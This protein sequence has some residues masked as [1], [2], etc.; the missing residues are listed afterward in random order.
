LYGIGGGKSRTRT[1]L[2]GTSSEAILWASKSEA[3]RSVWERVGLAQM[4]N[5]LY[6]C[7]KTSWKET[8]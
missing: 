1:V 6:P 3:S 4:L 5:F 2:A 7:F 8:F